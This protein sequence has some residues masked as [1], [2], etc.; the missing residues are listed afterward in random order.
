MNIEAV[1]S[2]MVGELSVF[3]FK[4]RNEL[5]KTS[6]IRVAEQVK[7]VVSENGRARIVFAAA[8]SQAEFLKEFISMDDVPWN[9]ITAFHMDEYYT[10]PDSAPQRFG[11]FLK[12]HLFSQRP[13]G[14]VHYLNHNLEEYTSLIKEAPIDIVCMGIGENG[15]I[16]FNDPPVADFQDSEVIKEVELDV[17]C[18]QQQVND[19]EFEHIDHV[20]E[21]AVTLT[22]PTLLKGNFLSVVVPGST[23]AEAVK[24]TLFGE[25]STSCP[26]S[27]LRTHPNA[28]LFLDPDSSKLIN[29]KLL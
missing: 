4:D 8:V 1:H 16:A 22:I 17:T 13:F 25:I 7:K 9:K 20:P 27:I 29:D 11:N 21:K 14:K 28:E 26:A 15:H 18:R 12:E 6:A 2:L 3:T 24:N 19:G 5:G 10:L 23:K